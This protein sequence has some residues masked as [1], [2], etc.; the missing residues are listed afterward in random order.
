MSRAIAHTILYSH[1]PYEC[2]SA[3]RCR[4]QTLDPKGS[5]YIPE[6]TMVSMLTSNTEAF[7]EKEIEE[8]LRVSKDPETGMINYAEYVNL[9][10]N[11]MS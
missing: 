11:S 6:E 3:R 10:I 7:R 4:L 8:F 2:I 5:G 1:I 9:L